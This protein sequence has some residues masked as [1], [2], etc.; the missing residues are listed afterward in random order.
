ML[1]NASIS[2]IN[3]S[4][5]DDVPLGAGT[6]KRLEYQLSDQ[7]KPA[8]IVVLLSNLNIDYRYWTQKTIDL[9]QKMKKPII[10]MSP[11][12]NERVL[13]IV[14]TASLEMVEWNEQSILDVIKKRSIRP[15]ILLS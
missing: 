11:R 15:E 4:V 13:N 8:Q 6:Q 10:Y 7:I 14:Q 5:P 9:S 1:N 2:W 12:E 3:C